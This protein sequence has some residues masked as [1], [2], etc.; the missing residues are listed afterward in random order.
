M[1]QKSTRGLTVSAAIESFPRDQ[2][3]RIAGK[4]WTEHRCVTVTV[5]EDGVCGWAECC[6]VFYKNETEAQ[7]LDE[8]E[9]VREPLR[10]GSRRRDLLELLP[11]SAARNALDCAL[12]D[13]EAKQAAQ[14][15]W[16]LAALAPPVPLLTTYT[17]GAA[18]PASM[19][20]RAG[21]FKTARAIKLK[22]TG[23]DVDAERVRAV[24]AVRPDVWLG[25]DANQSYSLEHL[26]RLMPALL[27]ARVQLIE[28]PLPVGQENC[29]LSLQSPIPIAADESVQDLADLERVAGFA[30]VNLKLDKSGGLTRCLEIAH[31]ARRRGI[32]VMVG[33]MGGSSLAMAPGC[34]LGQLC[35]LVD[36]DGPTDLM[37]DRSP[38]ARYVDGYI[39]CSE[40]LWGGAG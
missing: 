5:E 20:V 35:D 36:L 13:L 26:E 9:K 14:P 1:R 3:F 33:C 7:I 30:V 12:W 34:V 18:D 24:R 15:V 4:T 21:S 29:L 32:Q 39:T 11:P 16:K 17:V 10:A 23:E 22:L 38:P 40:D 8:I 28:Q 19:A 31:E 27:E 6:G 37:R 25:V 2:P